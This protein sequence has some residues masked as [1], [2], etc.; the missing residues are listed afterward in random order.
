MTKD[1]LTREVQRLI[2][3]GQKVVGTK[4]DAGMRGVN[5]LSGRP[6]AVDLQ[7]FS[8]W[9]A[10]CKNLMRLLGD[11][12]ETWKKTFEGANTIVNA[13][14]MLGTLEAIEH[15]ISEGLLLNVEDMVRAESFNNLLDQA[16]FLQEQGFFIAAGVLGR[17]VLE[18]HL[19]AWTGISSLSISKPKPTLNDFKDALYKNKKFSLSVHKHIE[20]MAAIGNDAAHNKPEL[21]KDAVSRVLRD[22]REF[23]GKYP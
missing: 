11:C 12:A 22:V 9:Q 4:F 23:I 20:A 7:A 18:E 2:A 15:S 14:R 8:R 6:V 5:Y 13:T 10:G 21:T 17:A 19:R 3:E 16:D 1:L